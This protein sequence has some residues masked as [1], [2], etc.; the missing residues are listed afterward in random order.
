MLKYTIEVDIENCITCGVCYGTD[1]NHFEGDKEGKSRI[2]NGSTNG[3]S[4]GTFDDGLIAD[5]KR[6]ELSCPVTAITVKE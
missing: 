5:A 2:I 3:V 4:N 1:P 6:A